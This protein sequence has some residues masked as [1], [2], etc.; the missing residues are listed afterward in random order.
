[1]LFFDSYQR[2]VLDSH[3]HNGHLSLKSERNLE[4]GMLVLFL[5]FVWTNDQRDS[6]RQSM[7]SPNASKKNDCIWVHRL[8]TNRHWS[9]PQKR[10]ESW[11]VK[12]PVVSL[13]Q[14]LRTVID[15]C[16]MDYNSQAST[17]RNVPARI[18]KGVDSSDK[19]LHV[20]TDESPTGKPYEEEE[21]D[22]VIEEINLMESQGLRFHVG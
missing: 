13:G 21:T 12:T 8:F 19:F 22:D 10:F 17:S 15:D 3:I 6:W 18:T 4:S 9:W 7:I 11:D 16:P 5:S 1:M 14:S 2:Q 20:N